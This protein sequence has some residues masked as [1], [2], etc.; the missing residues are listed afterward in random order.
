MRKTWGALSEW[1]Q[2]VMVVTVGILPSAISISLF[3]YV[4][5][6]ST[7]THRP[8]IGIPQVTYTPDMGAQGAIERLRWRIVL[9]NTGSLPGW[10]HVEQR[11][12]TV[13]M[14]EA[15]IPVSLKQTRPEVRVFLMPGGE[16]V[17]DGEFPDNTVVHIQRVLAGQAVLRESIRFVYEPSAAMWWKPQYYHEATLRFL[18]GPSPHFVFTVRDWDQASVLVQ[19]GRLLDRTF[20]VRGGEI[21]AHVLDPT[22]PSSGSPAGDL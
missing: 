3:V 17:L 15:V 21:A 18:A 1:A 20:P 9:T 8:Y 5:G 19:V 11:E 4:I 6:I 10:V 12:V 7:I 16:A 22:Q 13:T 2:V 14:G